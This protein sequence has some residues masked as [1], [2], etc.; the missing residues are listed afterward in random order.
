MIILFKV[1]LFKIS[2]VVF[3]VRFQ[4]L[5]FTTPICPLFQCIFVN[6]IKLTNQVC[7]FLIC[8]IRVNKSTLRTYNTAYVLYTLLAAVFTSVNR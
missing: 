7:Q 2:I 8:E 3:S 6:V 4:C 5:N 1:Q